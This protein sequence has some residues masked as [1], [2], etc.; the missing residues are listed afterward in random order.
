MNKRD[1][2]HFQ[3]VVVVFFFKFDALE[4]SV[5]PHTEVY[6]NPPK[7]M[8]QHILVCVGSKKKVKQ[9]KIYFRFFKADSCFDNSFANSSFFSNSFLKSSPEGVYANAQDLIG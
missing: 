9:S 6:W 7:L 8:K 2:T 3:F 4:C 1:L 5:N